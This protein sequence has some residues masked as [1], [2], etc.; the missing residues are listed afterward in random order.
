MKK[1]IYILAA[2]ALLA[3][4]SEKENPGNTNGGNEEEGGNIEL[5]LEQQKLI[6]EWHSTTLA[7]DGDIYLHFAEDKTFDM[8]QQIKEG[9]H[10]LYRGTWDLAEGL[11]TGR[12]NDG[13]DWAASYHVEMNETTMT[14]VSD[15]DA[16]EQSVFKKEPIPSEI[17]ETCETV[18]K[19]AAL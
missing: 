8:Y 6:G 15:N 11:L 4:C 10:R 9:A 2:A 7:I 3:A 13:E 12:Y 16:A 19:S 18:V 5:T 1:I 17:K 14:L